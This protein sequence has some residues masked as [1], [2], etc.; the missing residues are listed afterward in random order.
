MC[1]GRVI[2]KRVSTYASNMILISK[3]IEP[4]IGKVDL[5]DINSRFLETY[6]KTILRI[7]TCTTKDTP[8][9]E[10]KTIST[11]TIRD[12]HKLLK[13]CFKQTV[14]LELI[15]KNPADHAT[16]PKYKP[17]RRQIWTADVRM[18]LT[19]ICDDDVLRQAMNLSFSVS[20][21]IGEFTGL[22]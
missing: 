7:P 14:K 11:S 20:L 17:V 12:I 2:S 4:V 6:Y 8:E 18:H 21:R 9:E 3:C 5:S 15:E 19:E 10:Q 13:S 16:V 1:L 22:T